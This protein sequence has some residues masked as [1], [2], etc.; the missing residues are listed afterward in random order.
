MF[1][2]WLILHVQVMLSTTNYL[3]HVSRCFSWLFKFHLRVLLVYL[4]VGTVLYQTY[5]PLYTSLRLLQLL[6]TAAARFSQL[7]Q[8]LSRE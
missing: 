4:H 5:L 6:T 2:P 8:I 1:T 7:C 3:L